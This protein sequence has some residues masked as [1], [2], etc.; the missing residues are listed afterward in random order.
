MKARARKIALVA[1][2]TAALSTSGLVV[3]SETSHAN[4]LENFT[5]FGGAPLVPRTPS[6]FPGYGTAS[7]QN[8][9]V[10]NAASKVVDLTAGLTWKA[11]TTSSMVILEVSNPSIS[12][13]IQWTYLGSE[14][15]DVSKFTAPGNAGFTEN[16]ANNNCATCGPS[17][18]TGPA[19]MGSSNGATLIVPLNVTDTSPSR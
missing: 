7:G 16:N 17:P 10:N 13:N 15:A 14:S 5:I 6:E 9:V 12:Y 1:L 11:S 3:I 18:Q 19:S 2:S 8:N 4:S